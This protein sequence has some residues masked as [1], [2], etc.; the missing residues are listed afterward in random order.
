MQGEQRLEVL[1]ARVLQ[2]MTRQLAAPAGAFYVMEQGRVLRRVAGF[3]LAGEP[4]ESF[5]VGEGLVGE[6]GA[7]RPGNTGSRGAGRTPAAWNPRCCPRC[8]SAWCWCP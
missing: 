5:A 4:P 7:C 6:A 8:H 1:G 3:A 2:F